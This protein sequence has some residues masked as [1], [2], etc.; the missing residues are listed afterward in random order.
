M[1]L[2]STNTWFLDFCTVETFG[3]T[4]IIKVVF[5]RDAG[6]SSPFC[7]RP[8][9]NTRLSSDSILC[10]KISFTSSDFESFSS[11][12]ETLLLW[13]LSFSVSERIILVFSATSFRKSKFTS[14][15]LPA[16]DCNCMRSIQKT[17]KTI[18][19]IFILVRCY[20]LYDCTYLFIRY[21]FVLHL[22]Y[23]VQWHKIISTSLRQKKVG[24]QD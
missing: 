20:M 1:N 19:H 9:S 14:P 18:L 7:F 2:T 15:K 8:Q 4:I 13:T 22:G 3:I 24:A 16:A 21:L 23:R 11:R 12:V 10:T 5:V 6:V 17:T